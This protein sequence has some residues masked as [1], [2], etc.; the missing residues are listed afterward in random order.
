MHVWIRLNEDGLVVSENAYIHSSVAY[1]ITI[2]TV[3]AQY[4]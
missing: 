2:A 3:H 1:Y 4:M